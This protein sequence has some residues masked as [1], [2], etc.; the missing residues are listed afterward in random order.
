VAYKHTHIH[1]A[2][3]KFVKGVCPPVS[4][5]KAVREKEPLATHPPKKAER[6]LEVERAKRSWFMS[7]L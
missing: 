5:A 2:V 6:R 7:M 4:A 1:P 3:K